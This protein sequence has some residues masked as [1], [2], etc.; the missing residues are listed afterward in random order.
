MCSQ[1]NILISHSPLFQFLL[2]WTL[3]VKQLR[4]P[5]TRVTAKPV[6]VGDNG[7]GDFFTAGGQ[8][9]MFQV[10]GEDC[11]HLFVSPLSQKCPE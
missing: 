1:D 8:A 6:E 4:T 9:E 7:G 3:L 2:C 11:C 5:W 10:K